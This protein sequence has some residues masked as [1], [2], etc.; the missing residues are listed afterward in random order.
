MFTLIWFIS[1]FEHEVETLFL[2]F[3]TLE[4]IKSYVC[5][6]MTSTEDFEQAKIHNYVKKIS[7]ETFADNLHHISYFH[8]YMAGFFNDVS[9]FLKYIIS[10]LRK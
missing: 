6:D 9:F 1:Y 8:S 3:I 4:M 10:T 5:E 7:L 2:L